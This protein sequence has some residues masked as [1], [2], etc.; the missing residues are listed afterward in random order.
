MQKTSNEVLQNIG[1]SASFGIAQN[2]ILAKMASEINKPRGI[3]RI[4]PDE[5]VDF[6]EGRSIE[7]GARNR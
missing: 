5:L 2:R 7:R 1:L 6:F 4:L 3:H